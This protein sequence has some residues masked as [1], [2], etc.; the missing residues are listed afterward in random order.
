MLGMAFYNSIFPQKKLEYVVAPFYGLKD[1]R[2]AG[3]GDV[4]YHLY[5]NN[6]CIQEIT[7]KSEIA[8]YT[9]GNASTGP[10]F[11]K[12]AEGIH[13]LFRKCKEN[14]RRKSFVN[15]RYIITNK[16][17]LSFDTAGFSFKQISPL[18]NHFHDL[19]YTFSDAR[20]LF[21]YA[22]SLHF[23]QGDKMA[24]MSLEANYTITFP[25]KNQ[26]IRLRYFAGTFIGKSQWNSPYMYRM[27]GQTGMQDYLYDNIFLGRSETFGLSSQQMTNTDGNFKVLSPLGQSGKWLTALNISCS[28]PAFIPF[29]LF[30]DIGTYGSTDGKLELLYDAG[31]EFVVIKN[32]FHIYIPL[33]MSSKIQ[34]HLLDVEEK[35]VSQTIRFTLNLNRLQPFNMLRNIEDLQ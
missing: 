1:N 2:V 3:Y 28:T 15:Y 22:I 8:R 29:R 19:N 14:S 7:L 24:K 17:G 13:I 4:Q 26:D 25:W 35:D 33:L 16:Q 27:S 20:K 30:A 9:M 32:T 12:L 5:P 34:R 23:Q 31:I 21:P 10:I 11:T 6:K 18:R